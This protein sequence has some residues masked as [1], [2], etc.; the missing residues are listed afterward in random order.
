M[1]KTA[2][3]SLMTTLCKLHDLG[4]DMHI[5]W[6][7]EIPSNYREYSRQHSF[8][9]EL[10]EQSANFIRETAKEKIVKS[11]ILPTDRNIDLLSDT[12]KVFL[13]KDPE[14][15]IESYFRG[16]FTGV[17]PIKI[18]EFKNLTTI[19]EWLQYATESGLLAELQRFYI[20]WEQGPNCLV[21]DTEELLIDPTGTINRIEKFYNME[22]SSDVVLDRQ[23]YT[24]G[25]LRNLYLEFRKRLAQLSNF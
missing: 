12:K 24:R 11:H 17:Y 3:T 2:S 16:H 13:R 4:C 20:G 25:G 22:Q 10:N 15:I 23:K 6:T 14:K 21:C 8:C 1:P 7:G 9:W 19:E 5:T 18:S